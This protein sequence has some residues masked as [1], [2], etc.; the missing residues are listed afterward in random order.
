M[1]TSTAHPWLRFYGRVPRS[2]DYPE[3]TLYEAVAQTAARVPDAI[4]WD[5]LGTTSSYRDFLAAIVSSGARPGVTCHPGLFVSAA[6][7]PVAYT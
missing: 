5:F 3:V 4:A 2:L 1:S 6:A 7:R